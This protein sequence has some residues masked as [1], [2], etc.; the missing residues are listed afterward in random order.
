MWFCCS[1]SLTT[2]VLLSDT[3]MVIYKLTLTINLLIQRSLDCWSKTWLYKR[4]LNPFFEDLN[5]NLF[6]GIKSSLSAFI[7]THYM[8]LIL[9]KRSRYHPM[10]S[11]TLFN[12]QVDVLPQDLVKNQRRE[13]RVWTFQSLC[14]SAVEMPVQI[15]T[16]AN[17]QFCGFETSQDLAV[18]FSPLSE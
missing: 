11:G 2:N 1:A 3:Q 4:Y 16:D 10:H 15:Q 8:K 14:S 13:N 9:H 12:K 18:R 7:T 6:T 17:T 5:L